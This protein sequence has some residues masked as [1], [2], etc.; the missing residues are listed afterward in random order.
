MTDD[1]LS[2]ADMQTL[3]A[4]DGDLYGGTRVTVSSDGIETG[5]L[6][7]ISDDAILVSD[8]EAV[9]SR[10]MEF[11]EIPGEERVYFFLTCKGRKNNSD[12][13][14]SVTIV[15]DWPKSADLIKMM[16]ALTARVPLEYRS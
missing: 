8:I 10:P 13:L 12:E 11:P 4:M 3:A 5:D 2:A 6:F 14:G 7:F 15:L 16:R 9:V 1:S